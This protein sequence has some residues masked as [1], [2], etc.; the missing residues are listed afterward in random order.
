MKKAVL[1]KVVISAVMLM[2]YV[3]VY[4]FDPD[5]TLI[6]PLIQVGQGG[7]GG[8]GDDHGGHHAPAQHIAP[9][10]VVYNLN[11]QELVFT[12]EATQATFTYYIKE[13]DTEVTV[14][15]GTMT[16]TLGEED[17]VSL[18]TLPAGEYILLI[19]VGAYWYEGLFTKEEE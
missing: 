5:S 18:A 6:I 19:Q 7:P 16:L 12:G 14:D 2:S 4:A 15:Y 9:P 10:S 8:G 11:A 3:N 17:S 13:E 1:K